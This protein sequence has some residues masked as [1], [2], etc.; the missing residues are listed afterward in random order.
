MAKKRTSDKTDEPVKRARAKASKSNDRSLEVEKDASVISAS[1]VAAPIDDGATFLGDDSTGEDYDDSR[2]LVEQTKERELAGD[3]SIAPPFEEFDEAREQE[4]ASQFANNLY[5]E[6]F[7]FSDMFGE[8][9]NPEDGDFDDD[10]DEE[11]E[12]LSDA[13]FDELLQDDD[14]EEDEASDAEADANLDDDF[15]AM[16]SEENVYEDD[17]NI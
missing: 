15:D 12:K 11:F 7:Y 2:L 1:D 13:E 6:Q 10:F 17:D 4:Y 16:N 8:D 9:D 3:G 14:D 5:Q